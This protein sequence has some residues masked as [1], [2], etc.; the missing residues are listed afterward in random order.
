[1]G[2]MSAG[3]HTR[4]PASGSRRPLFLGLLVLVVL[5]VVVIIGRALTTTD[6]AACE[7]ISHARVAAAPDIVPVVKE[8][9]QGMADEE[10]CVRLEVEA[11]AAEEM[12]NQL[13]T[14]SGEAPQ[15]WIP[16]SSVWARQL[17]QSGVDA[18]T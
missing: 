11:V 16:D 4:A 6:A 15:M 9:A 13:V 5:I 10:R 14:G 7:G 12:L 3:L 2:D 17:N 8:L 1:G 18:E